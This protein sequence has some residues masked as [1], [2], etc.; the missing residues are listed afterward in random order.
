MIKAQNSHQR[1]H[2]KRL[3]SEPLQPH[4]LQAPDTFHIC[5]CTWPGVGWETKRRIPSALTQ[6]KSVDYA[7][8]P[9][10]PGQGAL[11]VSLGLK[12]GK[13]QRVQGLVIIS[14]NIIYPCVVLAGLFQL[15][16]IVWPFLKTFKPL[17]CSNLQL[18]S[19][20]PSSDVGFWVHQKI[21]P[22]AFTHLLPITG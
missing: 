2:R 19:F 16:P 10:W 1:W 6:A 18:D 8:L 17:Q 20:S 5:L 13:V 3:S 14:A 22:T 21:C 15:L 12:T 4:L 11:R 7:Y 9:L